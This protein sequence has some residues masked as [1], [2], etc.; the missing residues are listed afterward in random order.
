MKQVTKSKT[1]QGLPTVGAQ[2]KERILQSSRLNYRKVP[3]FTQSFK[4]RTELANAWSSWLEEKGPY[5]VMLT[6]NPS[7]CHNDEISQNAISHIVRALNK[8]IFGRHYLEQERGLSGFI[9]AEQNVHGLNRG[10]LH[11]HM[12]IRS[13]PGVDASNVVEV[14]TSHLSKVLPRV[15]TEFTDR[16]LAALDNRVHL[17]V[18]DDQNKV[19][20]YVTKEIGRSGYMHG[21]QIGELVVRGLDYQAIERDR[22][23]LKG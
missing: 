13:F 10:Q 14:L 9:T 11:Y 19:C 12:L 23:K 4:Q 21:D 16:E 5:L 1:S 2:F 7:N 22:Q 15:K 17:Q 20:D 8:R 18:V 3:S 6:V